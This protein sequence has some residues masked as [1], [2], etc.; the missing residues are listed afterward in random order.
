MIRR[1]QALNYRCLRFVDVALD[2]FHVLVGPNASGKSTLFDAIAFLGDLVSDGLE[3]AVDKRTRNFRD[4]VWKRGRRSRKDAAGFQLAVEFDIPRDIRKLLPAGRE[5]TVFRYEVAIE[6][7]EG[8]PRIASERGILAPRQPGKP[9]HLSSIFPNPSRPPETILQGGW[10]RGARTI[11]SKSNEGK[12]TFNIEVSPRSGRGWAPR[13][14][15]GSQRSVLGNLPE[16]PETFPMATYVKRTLERRLKPLFLDSQRM[17]RASPPASRRRGFAPDGSNLPWI[18]ERMRQEYPADYDEWL[19]HV[20]TVLS[21]LESIR[22]V[23][24]PDDR[25]AYPVLRYRTGAEIPSWMASDGTLRLLA[26]TLLAYLPNQGEI[27]VLEEPENGIHPMAVECVYQSL[28]SIYDSQ[29]LLATHSPVVLKLASPEDVLCFAKNDEGATD[30]VRGDRHPRAV[31]W[32]SGPPD[33][34]LLFATGVL[35]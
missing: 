23:E 5:F 30:V 24:R 35:G 31:D 21:D 4:L 19:A 2:S 26:L 25:H 27:Y 18:V 13:I 20:Q 1:I 28:S 12:D 33:M 6:E 15:F 10:K 34:E 22:I 11:L 14:S 16:S 29:L 9:A 17:R 8:E 32:Q 3:A 7:H